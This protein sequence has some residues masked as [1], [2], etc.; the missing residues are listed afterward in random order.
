M[1]RKHYLKNL[2]LKA[3]NHANKN[4]I[5]HLSYRMT[6]ILGGR[7][8]HTITT[9]EIAFKIIFREAAKPTTLKKTPVGTKTVSNY[10]KKIDTKAKLHFAYTSK[11]MTDNATGKN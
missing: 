7:S 11:N 3:R 10:K 8:W 4:L 9:A 6:F 5:I 1:R 2:T